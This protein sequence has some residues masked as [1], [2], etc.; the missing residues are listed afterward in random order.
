MPLVL[1][2]GIK[3]EETHTCFLGILDSVDLQETRQGPGP[4]LGRG[5]FCGR[6]RWAR[7]QLPH[8]KGHPAEV[9]GSA[10]NLKCTPS[11]A[12]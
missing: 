1:I 2:M 4:E 9:H 8:G 11:D 10:I 7:G 6:I 5:G 3:G 12:L